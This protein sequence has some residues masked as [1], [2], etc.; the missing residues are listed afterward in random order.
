MSIERRARGFTSP[1][2]SFVIPTP[3]IMKVKLPAVRD[4]H[5]G[6]R[7][8]QKAEVVEF[9]KAKHAL[10]SVF[11]KRLKAMIESVMSD[12]QQDLMELKKQLVAVDRVPRGVFEEADSEAN[13]SQGTVRRSLSKEN[14]ENGLFGKWWRHFARENFDRLLQEAEPKEKE[15]GKSKKQSIRTC[16][17]KLADILRNDLPDSTKQVFLDKISSTATIFTDY[18][19]ELLAIVRGTILKCATSFVQ[20]D[21]KS[22]TASVVSGKTP[23]RF[24]ASKVLPQKEH[25]RDKLALYSDAVAGKSWRIHRQH[26]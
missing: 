14:R 26:L 9:G 4:P 13:V 2:F 22:K 3:S 7:K 19:S 24:E 12:E 6:K 10:Y 5:T 8:R 16:S 1:I 21:V 15:T 20:L 11:E 17:T 18:I 25:I 23:D